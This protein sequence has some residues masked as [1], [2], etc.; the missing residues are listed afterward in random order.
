MVVSIVTRPGQEIE[1]AAAR[2]LR[3]RLDL[4]GIHRNDVEHPVGEKTDGLDADLDDDDDMHRRR[5]GQA[6]AESAAQIDDR[7]HDAAQIEHAAH[8][9]GLVRQLGDARP[10][11]DLAHRHDV[12]AILLV[13]DGEADEFGRDGSVLSRS[14]GAGAPAGAS[15]AEELAAE[16]MLGNL[17]LPLLRT[18][19]DDACP[20]PA[21]DGRRRI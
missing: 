10:A 21:R 19:M 3:H 12:D 1:R 6:L 20:L 14:F 13:A 8:I 9:V 17:L 5:V 15:S 7:H 16:L 18:R 2:H 11:F 4:R